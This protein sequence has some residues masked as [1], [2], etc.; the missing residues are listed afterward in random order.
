MADDEFDGRPYRDTLT[1]PGILVMPDDPWPAEFYARYPEA[2]RLPVRITW[3][4]GPAEEGAVLRVRSRPT[5][6]AE[7][8]GAGFQLGKALFLQGQAFKGEVPHFHPRPRAPQGSPQFAFLLRIA[9]TEGFEP[10]KVP[11]QDGIVVALVFSGQ[12]HALGHLDL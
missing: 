4:H 2:F 8:F 9:M 5:L 1:V 10:D 3:R 11:G 12:T 6:A 7:Q